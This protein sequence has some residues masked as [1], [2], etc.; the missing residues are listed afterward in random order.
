MSIKNL[1]DIAPHMRLN[2]L[3]SNH[4]VERSAYG[5][6]TIPCD[7]IKSDGLYII[8][9]VCPIK[10]LSYNTHF[11]VT[12]EEHLSASFSSMTIKDGQKLFHP[13]INI[14][15][16]PRDEI[17]VI[18]SNNKTA[19]KAMINIDGYSLKAGSSQMVGDISGVV[20]LTK[21]RNNWLVEKIQ[22]EI[23]EDYGDKMFDYLRKELDQL[24][25]ENYV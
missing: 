13:W 16:I 10:D 15:P 17:K 12:G 25:P 9:V 14:Y 19:T 21:Y 18:M 7:C 6:Y 11:P 5:V 20:E 3:E 23:K 4:V 2:F 8:K 22:V 24:D 1:A